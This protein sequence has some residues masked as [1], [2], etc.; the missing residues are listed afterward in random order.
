M[1]IQNIHIL[2]NEPVKITPFELN[3]QRRIEEHREGLHPWGSKRRDCPLCQ[4]GQ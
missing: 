1:G 2:V 3:A 4:R